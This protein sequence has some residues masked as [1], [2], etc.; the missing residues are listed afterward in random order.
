MTRGAVVD[1]PVRWHEP[2]PVILEEYVHAVRV[3]RRD[4]R[5]H[6]T[7]TPPCVT[8]PECRD[9]DGDLRNA[10]VRSRAPRP[11]RCRALTRTTAALPGSRASIESAPSSSTRSRLVAAFDPPAIHSL[12]RPSPLVADA[13][14]SH[15]AHQAPPAPG[16]P[17]RRAEQ[18]HPAVRTQVSPRRHEWAPSKCP[19]GARDARP[20]GRLGVPAAARHSTCRRRSEPVEPSCPSWHRL[21]RPK[22]HAAT[23]NGR[24]SFMATAI[25]EIRL[26]RGAMLVCRE[27]T[28]GLS[29]R[30]PS[31]DDP[32]GARPRRHRRPARTLGSGSRRT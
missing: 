12:M 10:V 4:Q 2:A 3:R 20:A 21:D 19:D 7:I 25:A 5:A 23:T 8:R 17:L 31:R 11:R 9:L 14:E 13:H 24:I 6:P 22:V 27:E 29:D 32:S 15:C 28:D 26:H 1:R 18:P 30:R 16:L